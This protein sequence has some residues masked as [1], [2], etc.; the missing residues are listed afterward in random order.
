VA[1]RDRVRLAFIHAPTE[2]LGDAV[3]VRCKALAG[4]DG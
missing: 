1:N 4:C 2:G 3:D